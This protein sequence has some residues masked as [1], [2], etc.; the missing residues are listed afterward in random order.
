M[1]LISSF[2]QGMSSANDTAVL[3][4]EQRSKDYADV[5]MDGVTIGQLESPNEQ[6]W[7]ELY[8]QLFMACEDLD[9]DYESGP[10]DEFSIPESEFRRRMENFG[11]TIRIDRP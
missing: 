9:M 5:P 6:R 4:F 7:E 11:R 1:S 3:F 10:R 2:L 8:E